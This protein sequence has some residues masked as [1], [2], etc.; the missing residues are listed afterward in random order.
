MLLGHWGEALADPKT[1]VS[2]VLSMTGGEEEDV[3]QAADAAAL[4]ADA[5]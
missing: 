5:T 3:Q 1:S 2:I 4:L